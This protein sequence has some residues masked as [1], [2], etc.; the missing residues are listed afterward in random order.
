MRFLLGVLA[1]DVLQDSIRHAELVRDSG[2]DW[3]IVRVPV[4]TDGPA[5]GN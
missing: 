3:T 2:L 1:K 4:L 5:R